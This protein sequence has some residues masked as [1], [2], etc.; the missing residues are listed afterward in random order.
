[1]IFLEQEFHIA[2]EF[3]ASA[4]EAVSELM[5]S[6]PDGTSSNRHFAFVKELELITGHSLADTLRAWRWLVELDSDGNIQSI[7]FTGEKRGDDEML[8]GAIA[9]YVRP[10]SH[11]VMA[12]DNGEVW[13]WF[14]DGQ[15]VRRQPGQITFD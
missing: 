5:G 2:R 15:I 14:F 12:C 8:F 4:L 13:R 3:Q 6:K 11:I 9:P 7:D 1:M 10:G